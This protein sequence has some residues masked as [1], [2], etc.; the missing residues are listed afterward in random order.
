MST[1]LLQS[2]FSQ[3]FR[4]PSPIL[5][6][7]NCPDQTG[8]VFIITGGYAGIGK[9]LARLLYA[10]NATIYIAGRSASKAKAAIASIT[11]DVSSSKGNMNFM[12][13]DLSNLATIKPSVEAFL[14]KESRLDVLVNNAGVMFPPKGTVD[15]QGIEIQI[16]TNCV[17]HFLLHK[18]LQLTLT[19][20]AS[21]SPP[22]SVRVTWAGSL[23]IDVFSPSPGGMI[24][25]DTGHP[26]VLS[27]QQSNYG[28][29]KAGNL[30][31]AKAY[32]R[33]TPATGVVHVC[34]NPG[35]LKTELQRHTGG[36][37]SL[38][39][40]WMLYP[41]I[42]GGYTELFAAVSPEITDKHSGAYIHP[43]GRFG[44]IRND[45]ALSIK[46]DSDGGTGLMDRFVSW[47]EIYTKEFA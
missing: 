35:N 23:G 44:K 1:S 4:L 6:E 42:Y 20:T 43:W 45:I 11:K 3:S 27:S 17:G 36:L 8:R 28:A 14:A 2:F 34:F 18:L 24:L 47:C 5:T 39:T 29:S 41:A 32:A 37:K 9:E 7:A 40:E 13:L 33:D 16:G 15:S 26:V 19:R 31:F 25:D 10:H 46:S 22:G 21:I 38:M 12:G 30:L